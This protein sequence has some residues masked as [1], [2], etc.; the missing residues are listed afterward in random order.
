MFSLHWLLCLLFPL[1]YQN[2][3]PF[4][5]T[6]QNLISMI[7]NHLTIGKTTSGWVVNRITKQVG[8]YKENYLLV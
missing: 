5:L 1:Y 3:R 8:N 4:R 7:R 6:L 2:H